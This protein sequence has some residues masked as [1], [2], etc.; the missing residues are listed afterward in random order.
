YVQNP[1]ITENYRNAGYKP[2]ETDALIVHGTDAY[3]FGRNKVFVCGKNGY[4]TWKRTKWTKEFEKLSTEEQ[5]DYVYDI[6]ER[7]NTTDQKKF[8]YD[9]VG[10]VAYAQRNGILIEYDSETHQAYFAKKANNGEVTLYLQSAP[11]QR[12]ELTR[13]KPTYDGTGI[14]YTMAG[15]DGILY[16]RDDQ[17]V[18][19]DKY[20]YEEFVTFT[21]PEVDGK[22]DDFISLHYVDLGER[23][24]YSIYVD[25][26]D[27]IWIDTRLIGVNEIKRVDWDCDRVC[28]TGFAGNYIYSMEHDNSLLAKLTYIRD[29][30]SETGQEGWKFREVWAEDNNYQRI[31]LKQSKFN[32]EAAEAERLAEETAKK[33]EEE[34][35]NS[36]EVRFPAPELKDRKG[37]D[38][39]D[40]V[41][42]ESATYAEYIGPQEHFS[43][44]YPPA[45]Y[46][47]VEYTMENEAKDIDILFTC[48]E[49]QGTLKVSVHPLP[50]D[51]TDIAGYAKELS[52]SECGNLG[53]GKEI[54]F[55]NNT[56]KGI[57]RFELEGMSNEID[58]A[59]CHVICQVDGDNVMKMVITM[60]NAKDSEEDAV[61]DFLVKKLYY[62]CGFGILEKAP[63]M[64]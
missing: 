53:Y 57:C 26:K 4:F 33:A 1:M 30:N 14:P 61:K 17:I 19:I 50:A 49:D 44:K 48:S 15:S 60:P 62:H 8:S 51:V 11:N 28:V 12:E 13:F 9:E 40:K 35:L 43:F 59:Q 25:D 7:Q 31:E 55:K 39:Y 64:K 16:L 22:T 54:E 45:F 23:G 41:Y 3:V 18:F 10:A 24:K 32:P 63:V 6:L 29:I 27:E 5:F 47:H 2:K 37:R 46:D 34:R 21:H 36:P 56:E 52:S 58:D 20:S 42:I 38:L